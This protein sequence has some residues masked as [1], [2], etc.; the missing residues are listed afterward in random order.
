M[1]ARAAA[2][3]DVTTD[4]IDAVRRRPVVDRL[5]LGRPIWI[6]R[7]RLFISVNRHRAHGPP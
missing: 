4:V 1:R 2:G 5:D 7:F 3:D 6:D